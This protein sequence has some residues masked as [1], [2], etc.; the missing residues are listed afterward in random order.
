VAVRI[1]RHS[2]VDAG[3][4]R[5]SQDFNYTDDPSCHVMRRREILKAQPRLRAL[6]GKNPCSALWIVALV[7]LQFVV[8]RRVGGAAWW[9][10]LAASYLVGAFVNHALYVLTHECTHDLVFRGSRANRLMGIVCDFATVMPS[11]MSFRKYHLLH[12]RYLG[13]YDRDP[14]IVSRAEARLIGN[15]ALRKALWLFFLSVSQALRPLKV[16][17]V[18]MWDRWLGLNVAAVLLI[19]ALVFVFLG[20]GALAYLALSTLFALGL[21][22]VGG[23]WIQEHYLTQ[24]GQET[25]SYYGPLNRLCFNMGFHNEHHDFPGIPW[26]RLPEVRRLAPAYYERLKS[27]RSWTGVVWRYIFD[28]DL[29]A[30]SRIVRPAQGQARQPGLSP[31]GH[32]RNA[33][34]TDLN[35]HPREAHMPARAVFAATGVPSAEQSPRRPDGCA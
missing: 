1:S 34:E 5:M 10:I 20:S 31:M 17:G 4:F 7:S 22:P 24:A 29:S 12:H 6:V 27:Y 8:A 9:L 18:G 2:P 11:A 33:L 28:P 21:H 25:Y 23:R 26:N 16:R 14:D 3:P 19:D 30:Y 15:S 35:A 32:D 13:R